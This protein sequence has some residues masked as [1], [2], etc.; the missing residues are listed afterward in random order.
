MSFFRAPRNSAP[1]TYGLRTFLLI[2]GLVSSIGLGGCASMVQTRVA[3]PETGVSCL[4]AL[5][6]Y[7]LPGRDIKVT[8]A[9]GT[10]RGFQIEKLDLVNV[11]R[12]RILCLDYLTSATSNDTL[13]TKVSQSG[14][15]ELIS[16]TAEDQSVQ[17][18]TKLVETVAQGALAAGRGTRVGSTPI[19]PPKPFSFDPFDPRAYSQ[20]K[21]TLRDYGLCLVIEGVHVPEGGHGA[22][23]FCDQRGPVTLSPAAE[24]ARAQPIPEGADARGILYRPLMSYMVTVL[25]K[26][27]PR[28]RNPWILHRREAMEFPDLAPPLAVTVERAVFATRKTR[29]AFAGGVLTDVTIDKTSELNEFSRIPLV[30]AQA[31]VAIPGQ[32]VTLRIQDASR[33]EKLIQANANLI[34][35]QRQYVERLDALRAAQ[36]ASEGRAGSIPSRGDAAAIRSEAVNPLADKAMET[37]IDA[38]IGNGSSFDECAARWRQENRR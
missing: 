27:D 32:I 24:L 22:E 30:V 33:E 14:L 1:L 29:L 15:L 38:C 18:A 13:I 7:R 12:S 23:R 28:G 26:P 9:P 37:F 2:A 8:I 6:G 16:T 11:G 31:I 25:R 17:I 3:S 5:P 35:A 34:D 21:S 19:E 20:H 10:D 36:K 4:S